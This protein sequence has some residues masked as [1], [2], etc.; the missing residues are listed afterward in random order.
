M[1]AVMKTFW[2][3]DRGATMIEYGLIATL[4]SIVVIAAVAMTGTRVR[5][6]FND[7]GNNLVS[8]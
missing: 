5:Q 2:S 6:T 8:S 7:V 3:D 4:I 1:L